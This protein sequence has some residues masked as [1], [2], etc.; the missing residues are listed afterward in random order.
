MLFPCLRDIIESYVLDVTELVI[1]EDRDGI[2]DLVENVDM[3]QGG[4]R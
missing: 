2:D 1:V 3:I 4:P